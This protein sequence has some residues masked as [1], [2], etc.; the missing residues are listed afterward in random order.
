MVFWNA[1]FGIGVAYP[2]WRA[3]AMSVGSDDFCWTQIW[4]LLVYVLLT[5]IWFFA[6]HRLMHT[7]MLYRRIHKIHHKFTAPEAIC[8]V[9]CHPVEMVVVNA[10]SMMVGPVVLGSHPAI[11]GLWGV[12]A[13]SSVTISHSGYGPGGPLP[14]ATGLHDRHHE[15]FNCNYGVALYLGDRLFGSYKPDSQV[16]PADKPK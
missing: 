13:T 8:G 3:R 1:A 14:G 6:A 2:M 12:I 16:N 7:K 4:H 9:Y 10:A 11:W 15:E 5:D